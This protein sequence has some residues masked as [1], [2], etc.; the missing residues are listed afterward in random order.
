MGRKNLSDIRRFEIVQGFARVFARHGFAKATIVDAAHEAGLAPALLHHYFESKQAIL[1]ALVTQLAKGVQA[2]IETHL[3][4][5]RDLLTS[6]FAAVLQTGPRADL[7]AA[8]CWVG[9]FAEGI[10]DASL[11]KLV[12]QFVAQQLAML[13]RIAPKLTPPQRAAIVAYVIGCLVF[14]A[15]A[16]SGYAGFAFP[17]AQVIADAFMRQ[18]RA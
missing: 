10:A 14:G 17:Q 6:Y 16:P 18:A 13:A 8:R 3:E 7:Q 11:G 15:F 1:T 4:S 5:D 9:I 12:R 2:R